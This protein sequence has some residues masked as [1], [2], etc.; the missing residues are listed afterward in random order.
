MTMKKPTR[1]T[2][3]LSAALLAALPTAA[4]A[5]KIERKYGSSQSPIAA[6]VSVPAAANV[7]Y[8]SGATASPIDPAKPDEL[9]DTKAQTLNILTKI[10]AQLEAMGM[11]MGDVVKMTVFLV[12]TPANGGKMD[13]PAMNE[14]FRT[15]FGSADQPNK[16]ARSTV[17]VAALGRPPVLVEIEAVAAKMP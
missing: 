17:Q 7:V 1:A 14:I 8:L 2:A 15:F 3:I 13:A 11:G 6:S 10:K 9:G 4:S 16:P 12:G 5:Q